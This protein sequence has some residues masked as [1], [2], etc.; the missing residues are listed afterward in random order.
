MLRYF[1]VTA[2]TWRD[3][4]KKDP[5]FLQSESPMLI[6]RAVVA[7][8][9]DPGVM[10]WTGHLTSSWEVAREYKLTDADGTVRDWGLH[11]K[12]VVMDEMPEMRAGTTRQIEWLERIA[13][14]LRWYVGERA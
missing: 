13:G 7:L 12:D 4:G 6:G 10:R 1:G 8:A 11:W 2:E 3:G 9:A 5:H 14:R